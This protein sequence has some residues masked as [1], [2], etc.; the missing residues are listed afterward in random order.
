MSPSELDVAAARVVD[1]LRRE[2]AVRIT[3]DE[4]GNHKSVQDICDELDI[5][6]GMWSRIKNHMLKG[7]IHICYKPGAGHYLGSKGEEV[8]NVVYKYKIACGWVRHLN[9]TKNAIRQSSPEAQA[10]IN[11]RFKDL[12]IE[13]SEHQYA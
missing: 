12:N 8:V 1:Y 11:R 4:V 2:N 5:Y 13:E 10:W 9:D 6:V 7:G 3:E